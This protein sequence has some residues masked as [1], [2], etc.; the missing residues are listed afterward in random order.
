MLLSKP[1]RAQ[2]VLMLLLLLARCYVGYCE[3]PCAL[4]T[5]PNAVMND[6]TKS[7]LE[8]E[9]GGLVASCT[10]RHGCDDESTFYITSI[11]R[12][13]EL[14][15][16]HYSIEQ[17]V[18]KGNP[19]AEKERLGSIWT[20]DREYEKR[21]FMS[22]KQHDRECPP[23]FGENYIGAD[24]VSEGVFMSIYAWVESNL[25]S[26]ATFK[27][28]LSMIPTEA[29]SEQGNE[30]STE[31][32]SRNFDLKTMNISYVGI[33]RPARKPLGGIASSVDSYHYYV[34]IVIDRSAWV[35]V[36]D[37]VHGEVR[38]LGFFEIMD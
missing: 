8:N 23:P 11:P 21:T 19:V 32:L 7:A 2:Q 9:Y 13:G 26:P 27:R 14:G 12:K 37:I 6:A 33:T 1:Y 22:I 28:M 38:P 34:R 10:H 29:N 36:L 24:G 4:V 20:I 25:R 17:V 5:E 3:T 31:M 35:F 15:V 30:V 16:C 18:S